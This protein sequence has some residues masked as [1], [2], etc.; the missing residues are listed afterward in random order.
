MPIKWF[1]GPP[2][3]LYYPWYPGEA[4][5]DKQPGVRPIGIGECRQ[6]IE[7][8]AMALARR[9]DVQEACGADQ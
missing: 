8:K 5:L 2:S 6:W 7:A 4:L 3:V 9:I 1:H